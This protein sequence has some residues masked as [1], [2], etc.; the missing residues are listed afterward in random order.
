MEPERSGSLSEFLGIVHHH[1]LVRWQ[2]RCPICLSVS[3]SAVFLTGRVAA[4]QMGVGRKGREGGRYNSYIQ[5][6]RTD[7]PI[8][9]QRRHWEDGWT[10]GRTH[11]VV[12]GACRY[13]I[14]GV[15]RDVGTRACRCIVLE[16]VNLPWPATQ[17]GAR[18]Q[19]MRD[20]DVLIIHTPFLP[21]FPPS[22]QTAAAVVFQVGPPP[23]PGVNFAAVPCAG[24]FLTSP[25]KDSVYILEKLLPC[26]AWVVGS[27]AM[28]ISIGVEST[29]RIIQNTQRLPC[30]RRRPCGRSCRTSMT[31][32]EQWC[33][34]Y[35]LPSQHTS[36]QDSTVPSSTPPQVDFECRRRG[37]NREE[38]FSFCDL[39]P[40]CL[41]AQCPTCGVGGGRS[42]SEVGSAKTQRGPP[43]QRARRMRSVQTFG[44]VIGS[45]AEDD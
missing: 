2:R 37:E 28:S 8:R 19:N 27:S 30:Q 32:F 33:A 23:A 42:R 45:A 26:Y 35:G 18:S 36:E 15:A 12:R 6:Q 10:D 9:P 13:Y 7:R 43:P 14:Q 38:L 31:L 25:T 39:L 16:A 5:K 21:S 1:L 4:G 40:A 22:F 44:S 34:F 17:K 24:D 41:P 29:Y 11:F 3:L 20:R